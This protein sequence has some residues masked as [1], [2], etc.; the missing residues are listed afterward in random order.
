MYRTRVTLDVVSLHRLS[1]DDAELWSALQDGLVSCI[2][3]REEPQALSRRQ[4]SLALQSQHE[5]VDRFFASLDGWRYVLQPGDE[6]Y[7]DLER[8][9]HPVPVTIQTIEYHEQSPPGETPAGP[10]ADTVSIVTVDG[11]RIEC[12]VC[13]LS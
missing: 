6:V 2:V 11:Q 9:G 7:V 3:T 4:F 10:T 5:S 1:E 8:R 12:R 13:E